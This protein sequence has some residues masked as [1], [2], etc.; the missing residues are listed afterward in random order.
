MIVTRINITLII[1]L[2]TNILYI[3]INESPSPDR[4]HIQNT[5][6]KKYLSCTPLVQSISGSNNNS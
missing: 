3:S 6:Y 1:Y 2:Y 4:G 5:E